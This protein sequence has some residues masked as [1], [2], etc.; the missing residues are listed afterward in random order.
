MLM[1]SGF[2]GLQPLSRLG[3]SGCA[4][5]EGLVALTAEEPGQGGSEGRVPA[6]HHQGPEGTVWG[7]AGERLPV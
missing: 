6:V 1:D 2:S 4:R 5:R 3:V 7:E